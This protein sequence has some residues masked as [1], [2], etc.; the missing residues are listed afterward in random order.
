[1]TIKMNVSYIVIC[2]FGMVKIWKKVSKWNSIVW[3][4]KNIIK[5]KKK[6]DEN[7]WIFIYDLMGMID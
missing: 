4:K 7:L 1:M 2:V 3:I 5:F 6:W